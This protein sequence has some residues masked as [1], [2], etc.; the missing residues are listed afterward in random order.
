MVI[1]LPHYCFSLIN[2]VSLV[3]FILSEIDSHLIE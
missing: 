3:I 2:F 1:F